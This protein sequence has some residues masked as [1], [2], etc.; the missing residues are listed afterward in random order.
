MTKKILVIEDEKLILENIIET[1]ELEGFEAV[2]AGNGLAG[3]EKAHKF[4]P[5]LIVCDIMMPEMDGYGVLLELRSH[6]R[7]SLI[8]FIFLTARSERADF[9]YGMEIGADDYITKPFLPSELLTAVKTRLDKK[10]ILVGKFGQDMNDLR[11]NIIHALPH[12]LRTPLTGI[13]AGTDILM[14]DFQN[15]SHT[16]HLIENYLV[17][18]Q[19]ELIANDQQKIAA[20]RQGKT[21][22]PGKIIHEAAAKKALEVERS[23]DLQIDA[24]DE[25]VLVSGEDLRKIAEELVDNALKF[26]DAGKSVCVKGTADSG[27]YVFTVIDQGRGMSSEQVESIGAYMQ[28][29]RKFYEQQGLGLGLIVCKRLTELYGGQFHIES[30]PQQGTTITVKLPM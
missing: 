20:M 17:Y 7:M 5:D 30:Q 14:D 18:A 3:L 23:A 29:E 13:M 6:P 28:F 19:I 4:M 16:Q 24:Q 9:R 2:G 21:A 8:P 11:A 15:D 26:S 12:E 22:K 10:D 27:Y 25:M 1:L